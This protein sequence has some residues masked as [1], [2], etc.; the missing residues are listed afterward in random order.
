MP[1]QCPTTVGRPRIDRRA[2]LA[3][4]RCGEDGRRTLSV[5][6]GLSSDDEP[7]TVELPLAVSALVELVQALVLVAERLPGGAMSLDFMMDAVPADVMTVAGDD[8]VR[9]D[10]SRQQWAAKS[11][12]VIE[13]LQWSLTEA[14]FRGQE[15]N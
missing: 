14:P 15:P 12:D 13:E 9:E 6:P 1:R 4:Q 10:R 3:T 2:V 7:A 5:W 8:A 11:R